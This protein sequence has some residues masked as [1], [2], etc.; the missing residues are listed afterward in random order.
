MAYYKVRI[1]VLCDWNPED[2]ALE[3]IAETLVWVTPFVRGAKWLPSFRARK[4]DWR[5]G[6]LSFERSETATGKPLVLP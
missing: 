3:E 6:P 5:H 2:S 1:E 4:Y